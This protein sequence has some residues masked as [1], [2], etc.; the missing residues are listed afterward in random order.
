MKEEDRIPIHIVG[1][2]K[3]YGE[4]LRKEIDSH[5]LSQYFI[6]KGSIT[7]IE[8]KKEYLKAKVL[9]YPSLYEGF[10]LPLAEA[11]S[12]G[13]PVITTGISSM[14]EAVGKNAVFIR[15]NDANSLAKILSDI[16]KGLINLDEIS[17]GG[18]SYVQSKFDPEILSHQLNNLYKDLLG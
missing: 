12:Q 2:L 10:G 17:S 8:L 13:C 5:N 14:P 4:R 6:F 7:D 11:L 3:S 1:T 9:I 16:S 15:P 18:S